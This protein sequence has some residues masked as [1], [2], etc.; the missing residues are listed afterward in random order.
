MREQRASVRS[1]NKGSGDLRIGRK[2][3]N[4]VLHMTAAGA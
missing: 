4:A 1:K 2:V 3:R